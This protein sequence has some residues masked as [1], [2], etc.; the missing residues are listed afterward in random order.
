MYYTLNICVKNIDDIKN[1]IHLLFFL[2]KHPFKNIYIFFCKTVFFFGKIF[3]LNKF[4]NTAA[5]S[6][7]VHIIL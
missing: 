7:L 4:I 1:F 6:F 5:F 2:D 3:F